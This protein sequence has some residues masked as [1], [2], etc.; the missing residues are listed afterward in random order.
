[1]KP[2]ARAWT[3]CGWKHGS[4]FPLGI[5]G[6]RRPSSSCCPRRAEIC[7]KFTID[8]LA[9]VIVMR[10]SWLC[11]K[12]LY[13]PAGRQVLMTALVRGLMADDTRISRTASVS[14][15]PRSC[16]PSVWLRA[17]PASM[18]SSSSSSLTLQNAEVAAS[19]RLFAVLRC[20]SLMASAL[21]ITMRS[22]IPQVKPFICRWYVKSRLNALSSCP[23]TVGPYTWWKAWTSPNFPNCALS[24]TPCTTSP[25][26]TW[27]SPS[28]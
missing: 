20:A 6:T 16:A 25:L 27:N 2:P 8:P 4:V 10:E 17:S 22:S 18:T 3:S 15:R 26:Y 21:G 24:S 5:L 11:R 13:C 7:E 19:P 1:M 12:G 14:G 28:P 9:P 23:L